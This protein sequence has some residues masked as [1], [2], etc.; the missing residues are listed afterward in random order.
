M[1]EIARDNDLV[2]L[3]GTLRGLYLN[4]LDVEASQAH[5]SVGLL[6][7]CPVHLGIGSIESSPGAIEH[8]GAS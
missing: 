4:E 2:V 7:I 6:R 3:D 8:F 1:L 5:V